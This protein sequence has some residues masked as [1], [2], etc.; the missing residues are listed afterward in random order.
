[1]GTSQSCLIKLFNTVLT[2][3]PQN[4]PSSTPSTG[5][6]HCLCNLCIHYLVCC[7]IWPPVIW[8]SNKLNV[9][10]CKQK[11]NLFFS[12]LPRINLYLCSNELIMHRLKMLYV[13]VDSKTLLTLDPILRYFTFAFQNGKKKPSRD[14]GRCI[15][16]VS[17]THF[18]AWK[19]LPLCWRKKCSSYN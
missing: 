16:L 19:C 8:W 18:S 10:R 17:V 1:M 6:S 15:S 5:V 9:L 12:F 13:N 11:L 14:R 4:Q 3:E 7:V 2:E